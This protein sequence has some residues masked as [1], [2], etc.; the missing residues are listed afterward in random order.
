MRHS[1]GVISGVFNCCSYRVRLIGVVGDCYVVADTLKVGVFRRTF[2]VLAATVIKI[3]DMLAV[4]VDSE[5]FQRSRHYEI[6]TGHLL[7][8]IRMGYIVLLFLCIF[9]FCRLALNEYIFA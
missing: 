6:R 5:G 8:S 7:A 4:V 3:G 9:P 2:G 1:H